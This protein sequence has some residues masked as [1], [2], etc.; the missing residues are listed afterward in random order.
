MTFSSLLSQELQ[1]ELAP[2]PHTRPLAG[3]SLK[4]FMTS[5]DHAQVCAILETRQPRPAS[6]QKRA[7]HLDLIILCVQALKLANDW[8]TLNPEV[9]QKIKINRYK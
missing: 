6:R 7:S 2:N 3:L 9:R 1:D 8:M 5:K 4:N